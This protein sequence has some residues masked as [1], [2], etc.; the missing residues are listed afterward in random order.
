MTD[1]V[2]NN[3]FTTLVEL[4]EHLEAQGYNYLFNFEN[5]PAPNPR[6]WCIETFYRFEGQSNPSDNS[7][8]YL[9]VKRDGSK[10]GIIVNS[11]SIYASGTVSKFIR[12]VQ[13]CPKK[14]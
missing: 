4:G 6:E 1:E 3:R 9:L 5:E 7:I 2:D 10:K 8:V 14:N 13:N 11:Y 12:E